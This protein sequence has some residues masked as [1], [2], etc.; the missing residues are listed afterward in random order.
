MT[1][2]V[3]L[4]RRALTAINQVCVLL[5]VLS[6]AFFRRSTANV[7]KFK[8]QHTA[9]VSLGLWHARV[10]CEADCVQLCVHIKKKEEE[11]CVVLP[12]VLQLYEAQRSFN[13]GVF[14]G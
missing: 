5:R 9:E 10:L 4:C 6:H 11:M 1:I 3:L 2:C 14:I 7:P 8:S 12:G 13:M